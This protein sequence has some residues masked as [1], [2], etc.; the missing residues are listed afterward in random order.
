MKTLLGIILAFYSTLSFSSGGIGICK[1]EYALCAA[2]SSYPT[3]NTITVDGVPFKEGKAVC[4]VLIGL[5]VANLNIMGSCKAPPNMVWSLFSPVTSYPQA[6]TWDV[7]DE[8]VRTFV[9]TAEIGGGMSNQWSYLCTK[10]KHRTK[11]SSGKYVQL[12]DCLGPINESPWT[13]GAIPVGTSI[14]TA[15][16]VGA[17]N[18][19]GGSLP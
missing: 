18:P 5:S 19:V 7:Q 3:G 8:V 15:A 1:G 4:P 9:T 14:I 10:Q 17:V 6:P 2:S 12:A 16:P 13:N 11:T